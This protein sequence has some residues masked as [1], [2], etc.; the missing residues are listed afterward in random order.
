MSPEP[1]L[2]V[3]ELDASGPGGV[4]QT[5]RVYDFAEAG[6]TLPEHEHPPGQAHITVVNKGRI[7]AWGPGWERV[8][9]AGAMVVFEP[10]KR[11]GFEALEAGSR[12][13]NIVY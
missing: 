5:L 11:H 3:K 8:L 9:E 13:T 12:V 6:W 4:T 10:G 7:R 1:I 2:Q